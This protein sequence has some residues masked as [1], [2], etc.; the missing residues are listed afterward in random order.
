MMIFFSLCADFDTGTFRTESQRS[1]Q[2]S[3]S[4]SQKNFLEYGQ[5]AHNIHNINTMLALKVDDMFVIWSA[6]K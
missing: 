2:L 4:A 6:A 1:Y 3:H 5:N